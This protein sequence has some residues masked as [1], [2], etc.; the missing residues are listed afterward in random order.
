M[1]EAYLPAL[2]LLCLFCLSSHNAGLSFFLVRGILFCQLS[3][4]PP[5]DT[6]RLIFALVCIFVLCRLLSCCGVGLRIHST[7]VIRHWGHCLQSMETTDH[8]L[9]ADG[10][11]MLG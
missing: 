6:R 1:P 3:Q 11:R 5:L 2:G 7:G 9:S 4:A 10:L 8:R